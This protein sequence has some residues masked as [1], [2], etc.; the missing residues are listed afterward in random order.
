MISIIVPA[1]NCE[2]TLTRCVE[3]VLSQQ[4]KDFELLLVDDGSTDCT[5]ALCDAYA[6][7]DGRV[8]AFHKP[9]G[10]VSSARNM[11][12]DN[13][14]GEWI[15]F[16]DSD[17]VLAENALQLIYDKSIHQDSESP[18]LIV[19]NLMII[20]HNEPAFA[21]YGPEL[22]TVSQL[23]HQGLWGSVWNKTFSRTL[24]DKYKIRFDESLRFSEDCLFVAEYCGYLNSNNL[25]YIVEPCYIQYEPESYSRKYDEFR[26]FEYN[27]DLYVKTKRV[28]RECSTTMV[29]GLVMS[30]CDEIRDGKKWAED[31]ERFKDAVGEDIVYALGKKK[32]VVRGLS[33][34]DSLFAWKAVLLISAKLHLV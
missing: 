6:A 14:V 11:G 33:R 22:Y 25:A 30:L 34:I 10:G 32:T 7:K 21:L 27:L 16:V 1:Y 15:T 13:A 26:S 2:S 8:R 28:N 20:H 17:D 19:E 23:Y 24:I 9:N 3:S 4:F 5:P 31:I 18:D 12:L 29:D